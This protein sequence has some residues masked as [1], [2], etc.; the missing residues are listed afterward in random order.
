MRLFDYLA[1]ED[2]ARRESLE[3]RRLIL[4]TMVDEA[5]Q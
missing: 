1:E 2:K 3:L 4:H 5:Y